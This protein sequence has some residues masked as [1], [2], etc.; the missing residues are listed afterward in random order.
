MTVTTCLFDLDG[1]IRHFSPERCAAAAT[2]H[3]V[4]AGDLVEAAFSSGLFRQV[5]TGEIR[6]ADWII[7]TGELIGSVAAARDWLTDIGTVDP[8]AVDVL[9][10]LRAAGF[11][12]AVLTNGTD[13]VPAELRTHGLD[14]HFD[15]VF[16]T[17]SIGVAKPEH[18][19]F[20]FVTNA[21]EVEPHQVFFTDDRPDN[22]E[23]AASLGF[24]THHFT[25][26][27]GLRTALA[28]ILR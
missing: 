18:G 10:D 6:K 1:V 3:D 28:P 11:T 15:E 16:N 8:H 5:I 19:A 20:H 4:D 13:E 24:V 7:G 25:G 26:V 14:Q 21:L 9:V 22:I 12:V 27:E 17:A 23:A 2:R